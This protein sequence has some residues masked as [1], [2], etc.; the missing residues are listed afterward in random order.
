VLVFNTAKKSLNPLGVV[1]VLNL[2]DG[3]DFSS[4]ILKAFNSKI[5]VIREGGHP[6]YE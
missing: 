2:I 3:S 1:K 4:I 6:N 5:K